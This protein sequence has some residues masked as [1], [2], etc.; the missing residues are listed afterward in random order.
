MKIRILDFYRLSNLGC[1][2]FVG[3]TGF[4]CC[5]TTIFLGFAR[6]GLGTY[7]NLLVG[8]GAFESCGTCER[9]VF[10]CHV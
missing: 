10:A 6:N 7:F 8:I 2:V 1:P 4:R 5:I 3:I 9:L